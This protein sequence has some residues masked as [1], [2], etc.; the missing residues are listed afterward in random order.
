[1]IGNDPAFPVLEDFEDGQLSTEINPHFLDSLK[2]GMTIRQYFVAQAMAGQLANP[3]ITSTDPR[4]F[5][6][7]TCQIADACLAREAEKSKD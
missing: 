7:A 1:M 4:I 6:I 2:T 3:D 5:A